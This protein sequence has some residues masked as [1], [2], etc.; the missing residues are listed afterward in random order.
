MLLLLCF[1]FA[2]RKYF[3][4]YEKYLIIIKII[5]PSQYILEKNFLAIKYKK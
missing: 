4:Y 2:I 1:S 5:I 3:E